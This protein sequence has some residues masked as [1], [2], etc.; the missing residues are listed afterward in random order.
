VSRCTTATRLPRLEAVR[1]RLALVSGSS[2]R[3]VVPAGTIKAL[4]SLDRAAR[5]KSPHSAL[6]RHDLRT[7]GAG[8]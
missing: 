7:C 8:T 6:G 4:L 3:K 2:T 1:Y 5:V